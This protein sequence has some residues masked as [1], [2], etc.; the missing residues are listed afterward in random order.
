MSQAEPPEPSVTGA[1]IFPSLRQKEKK[2]QNFI[3]NVDIPENIP[4][5][6]M[7]IIWTVVS[8]KTFMNEFDG[9]VSSQN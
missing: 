7:R 9:S 4:S 8:I 5:K 1:V 6:H 2:K 3:T